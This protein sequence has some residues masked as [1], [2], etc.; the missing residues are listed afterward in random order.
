MSI[1]HCSAG[2]VLLASAAVLPVAARA[3]EPTPL[4]PVEVAAANPTAAIATAPLSGGTLQRDTVQRRQSSTSDTAALL[5]LVPGVSANAGGGFS[6]MPAIHGLSEQRLRITID[7]ETIDPACPNDMNTPLSYTDPQTVG[8]MRVVTGV[9]PVS[10]GGDS[11]G[12]IIAVESPAP[13]FA[14]GPGGLAAGEASAFF[15]TNGDG[16][17]GAARLTLANGRLSATYSGS[18]TKSDQYQAGGDLG[19]VR[20][21]E[22]EK[23]DHALDLALQADAGLFRLKGGYHYSPGEGF[24]NQAMDMVSN[25]SWF[26]N[27]SYAGEF[28][29][30]TVNLSAG[31]R[32]IDHEMNFLEDKLPGDMPMTTKVHSFTTA[33]KLDLPVAAGQ[34]LRTGADYHHQWMDDYWPPVAGSM[35]MG[36]DT[37]V[38][39]NS[40]H[41]NRAGAFAEWEAHWSERLSSLVGA[42]YDRVEMN[43]GDV[44]PYSTNMMNMADAMAARAFNALDRKRTDNNW[45]ASALLSFAP[46]DDVAIELGYAHKARSPNLYERY[47]WGRGAMSS[48]M[49]GWYGDGNGYVG[50]PDLKPERADTL[51]AAVE[52]RGPGRAWTVRVA[53][54]YTH[55]ADYI[56]AVPVKS[57]AGTPWVQLR[58]AN[59]TAELYGVDVSGSATLWR[60][61]DGST[62]TL[63]GSLSWLHGE[64]SADHRPLY[65][66][67]PLDAKIGLTH[68]E[69]V[70]EA[71]VDVEMVASKDR[72]DPVRNE[73]ATA[74]YTLVNLRMAVN[75]RPVRLSIDAENLFDKGYALPLG[76][77]SLGDFKAT[78]VRRAVP[79]RG[80]SVNFGVSTRF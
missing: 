42:R 77:I 6:S 66:Q 10:M 75:L 13:R 51:S 67:M 32:D 12:G 3:A 78:G 40:G 60:R 1:R 18:Y 38:N 41:R 63:D 11:I 9:S 25:R 52:F 46:S 76:G 8:S 43:T 55:V 39:I 74:A 72:I 22:Y 59:R 69:G 36:P 54:W 29:W 20:S 80:R 28:D 50:N 16:F 71:G 23:T 53:P 31:Y 70:V 61:R 34:L 45:S 58:F 62:T 33:L 49:I 48:R 27:G 19:R 7:G 79:G 64:N 26:V 30:G 57:F 56:D 35:M 68:R 37:Y 15:R 73:P 5:R 65:H 24:A 44:A 4:P 21:T 47:A 14:T 17:G 2:A